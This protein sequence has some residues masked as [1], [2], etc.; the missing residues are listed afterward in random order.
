MQHNLVEVIKMKH[1]TMKIEGMSCP[2]CM[3]KIK[4]V[5]EERANARDV[6]VLFNSGR[7][8]FVSD[9]EK[10][11]EAARSVIESLGHEVVSVRIS[12]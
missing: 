7:V 1:V 5:L 11:A 3:G 6:E 2:S 12:D 4:Q 9:D 8:K 10:G